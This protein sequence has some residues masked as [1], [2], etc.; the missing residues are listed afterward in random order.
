MLNFIPNTKKAPATDVYKW[1][2]IWQ[3]VQFDPVELATFTGLREKVLFALDICIGNRLIYPDGTI[4]KI[5]KERLEIPYTDSATLL[6][7]LIE[8]D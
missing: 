7:G 5:I 3:G 2:W 6:K 1:R 8:K 4:S